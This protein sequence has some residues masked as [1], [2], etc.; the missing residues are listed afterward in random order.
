MF[1]TLDKNESKE[2]QRLSMLVRDTKQ[3]KITEDERKQ[4]CEYAQRSADIW[5]RSAPT[6]AAKERRKAVAR[7][8][9]LSDEIKF[10]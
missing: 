1:F 8:L 3:E 4:L 10:L 7:A 5:M 9:G 2:A 6:A